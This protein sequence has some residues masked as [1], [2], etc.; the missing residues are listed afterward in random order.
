[1][2]PYPVSKMEYCKKVGR[3]RVENIASILSRLGFSVTYEPVENHDVDIWVFTKTRNL[4]LVIEVINWQITSCMSKKKT[5]SIRKNFNQYDCMKLLV[6]SFKENLSDE[7]CSEEIDFD[8]LELGFQTQPFYGET[9]ALSD[10]DMRP[11]DY[12]TYR[13]VQCLLI[14]YLCQKGL[15]W[16]GNVI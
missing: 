4:I 8:V 11:D 13:M 12:S 6:T 3:V 7:L 9:D 2:Y 1:M 10:E 15:I 16:Y 5:K 14:K